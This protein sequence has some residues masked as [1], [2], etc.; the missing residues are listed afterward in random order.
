MTIAARYRLNGSYDS[1][2]LILDE[3]LGN[4]IRAG[5][6]NNAFRCRLEQVKTW[7]QSGNYA[8]A[9][10]SLR[11]LAAESRKSGLTDPKLKSDILLEQ[12]AF[13]LDIGEL[14][15]AK[16]FID[17][18]IQ[19]LAVNFG[20]NDTLTSLE[21]T[22]TMKRNSTKHCI[23]TKEHMI[24]LLLSALIKVRFLHIFRIKQL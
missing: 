18:C 17:Q 12:G 8:Q 4:C 5:D 7:R 3:A 19:T 24:F 13:Y 15:S 20:E 6:R 22:I 14:D 23:I 11:V 9:G 1:A 2:I 10:R 21:L 16:V